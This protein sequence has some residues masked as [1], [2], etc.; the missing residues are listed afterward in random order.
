MIELIL[1]ER[2]LKPQSKYPEQGK[3][4]P[5]KSHAANGAGGPIMAAGE[6]TRITLNVNGRRHNLLVEPLRPAGHPQPE[7][8]QG[9]LRPGRVPSVYSAHRRPSALRLHDPAGRSSRDADRHCGGT[10]GRGEAR[11]RAAGL[12]QRGRL[13]VRLLHPRTDHGGGM[14]EE[15]LLKLAAKRDEIR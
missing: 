1:T 4:M 14:I 2:V 7:R 8:D 13:P 10:D 6:V 12:C 15:E 9:R 3:N 11:C 5:E